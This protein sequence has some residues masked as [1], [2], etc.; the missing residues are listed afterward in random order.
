[1]VLTLLYCTLICLSSVCRG[2]ASWVHY[3]PCLSEPPIFSRIYLKNQTCEDGWASSEVQ[4]LWDRIFYCIHICICILLHTKPHTNKFVPIFVYHI[5][6]PYLYM[7]CYILYPY[8]E[9]TRHRTYVVCSFG[10]GS[11][12]MLKIRITTKSC[13]CINYLLHNKL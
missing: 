12:V 5:Y 6:I 9:G 2:V 7:E 10:G 1:M 4:K 13:F 8:G 11:S 3:V